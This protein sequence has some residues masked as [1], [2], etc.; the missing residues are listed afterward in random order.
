MRRK[1]DRHPV[2]ERLGTGDRI[3][4]FLPFVGARLADDPTRDN[5]VTTV[6]RIRGLKRLWPRT[7]ISSSDVLFVWRPRLLRRPRGPRLSVPD[8]RTVSF[9]LF[10][11]VQSVL[12]SRPSLL[13]T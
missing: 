9:L 6:P 1:R 11:S 10:A 7:A 8:A 5:G 3:A 12:P 4:D 2:D 13:A